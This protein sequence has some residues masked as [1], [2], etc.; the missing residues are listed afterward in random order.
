MQNAFGL[1]TQTVYALFGTLSM[2]LTHA[3]KNLMGKIFQRACLVGDIEDALKI[4]K[5]HLPQELT[6]DDMDKLRMCHMVAKPEVLGIAVET[7]TEITQS[8]LSAQKDKVLATQA[9]N[10]LYGEK[11]KINDSGV[12]DKIILNLMSK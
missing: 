3:Q 2:E 5:V 1:P 10:D 7:L 8:P 6:E 12:T 11:D 4:L 9:L